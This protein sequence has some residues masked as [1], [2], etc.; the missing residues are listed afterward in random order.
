MRQQ[1]VQVLAAVIKHVEQKHVAVKHITR[2]K[3]VTIVDITL[4]VIVTNGLDG[5]T[6]SNVL[7]AIHIK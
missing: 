6:K 7:L 2:K 4:H 3:A 5:I 1:H